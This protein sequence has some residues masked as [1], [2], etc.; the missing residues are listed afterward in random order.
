M[1]IDL[2]VMPASMLVFGAAAAVA[3]WRK[4]RDVIAA[5]GFGFPFGAMCGLFVAAIALTLRDGF[6]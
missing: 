4:E 1:N 6:A 5:L 3:T 2:I